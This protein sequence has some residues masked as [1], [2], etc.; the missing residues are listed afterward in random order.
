MTGWCLELTDTW[1]HCNASSGPKPVHDLLQRILRKKRPFGTHSLD[2]AACHASAAHGEYSS[3]MST[4]T[5]KSCKPPRPS[6]MR[7]LASIASVDHRR[8]SPCCVLSMMPSAHFSSMDLHRVRTELPSQFETVQARVSE[9]RWLQDAM[10]YS[11]IAA[12]RDIASF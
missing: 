1:P 9:T 7:R 10:T 8:S 6:P 12:R 2:A 4:W 11:G 5:D 3:Q